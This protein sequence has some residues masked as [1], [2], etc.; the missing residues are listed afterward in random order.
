MKFT[1]FTAILFSMGWMNIEGSGDAL[2]QLCCLSVSNTKIPV[3]NI[4]DYSVQDV[5][6]CP[7]RAVRFHTRKNKIICSDPDDRWTKKAVETVDRRK[8]TMESST[9]PFKANFIP[10]TPTKRLRKFQMG[11]NFFKE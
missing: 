3:G 4:L 6:T 10:T 2:P 5:V 11:M 8:L 1:L 7:V 9:E